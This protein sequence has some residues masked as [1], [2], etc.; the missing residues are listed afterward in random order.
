MK[1]QA[2]AKQMTSFFVSAIN[3]IQIYSRVCE[4]K[5]V[6]SHFVVDTVFGLIPILKKFRIKNEKIA[7][8]K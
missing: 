6:I 7:E 1:P 8:C 3:D 2:Q 5:Y 4:D